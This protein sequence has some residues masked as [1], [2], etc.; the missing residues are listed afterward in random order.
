MLEI[1]ADDEREAW[2]MYRN[3]VQSSIPWKCLTTSLKQ[4]CWCENLLRG[5]FSESGALSKGAE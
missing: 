4:R 5:S 1:K 2:P 3:L